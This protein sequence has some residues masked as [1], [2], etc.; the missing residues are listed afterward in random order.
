[1]AAEQRTHPLRIVDKIL[2]DGLKRL[3]RLPP[4]PEA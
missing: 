2:F 4:P 3:G 1:M